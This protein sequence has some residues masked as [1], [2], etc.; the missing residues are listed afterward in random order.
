MSTKYTVKQ[1][2]QNTS[3]TLAPAGYRL[4]SINNGDFLLFDGEGGKVVSREYRV[5]T[6]TE[7][8]EIVIHL[9]QHKS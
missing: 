5:T 4:D 7:E 3:R 8:L 9:D 6:A 1:N 2:G